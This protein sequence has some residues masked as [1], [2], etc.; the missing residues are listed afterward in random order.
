[1]K[2][3]SNLPEA[4]PV[5]GRQLDATVDLERDSRLVERCQGGDHT[6]FEELY[7]RYHAR[8]SVFCFRRLGDR[9]EA[10]DAAQEAFAKA[11][12][13]LP[14]FGGDRR[15]YPWLTV[16]AANVCTDALRRRSCCH[17]VSDVPEL[18][19]MDEPDVDEAIGAR[20]DS[21]AA[22][23]ALRKLSDR[24]RRVLTLRTE[25]S[26]TTKAIADHEGISLAACETLLW[27]A[28]QALKR[29]F[30]AITVTGTVGKVTS[31]L[32]AT[33]GGGT[34]AVGDAEVRVTNHP[35]TARRNP[36]TVESSSGDKDG[37][38]AVA[39]TVIARP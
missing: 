28:R 17:A 22:L 30:A 16:I 32:G 10:E 27:R 21:T 37:R 15:F 31:V 20:V 4:R 25:S 36:V 23:L 33:A 34:K 38:T 8:L 3:R 13:A 26:W 9:H 24:H 29:E 12:R 2:V 6:A 19:A 35:V 7:R 11:W 1:M 14:N 39:G 18:R 5:S